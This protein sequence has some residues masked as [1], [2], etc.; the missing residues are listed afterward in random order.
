M[1]LN[2]DNLIHPISNDEI[3]PWHSKPLDVH[4]W[5]D[6]PEINSLVGDIWSE[7]SEQLENRSNNKGKSDPKRQLKVLLLDLY[8]AWL[9]DPSLC[10]GLSRNNN[11]YFVGTRYNALHIS[12]KIVD[13][14]DVLVAHGYL[15][16][17]KGSY[18]RQGSGKGNRTSRIRPSL[19]LQDKFAEL[20]IQLSDIDTHYY[21]EML[22][23]SDFET[24][25]EGNYTKSNGKKKRKYIEY[26][27]TDFTKQM[28]DDLAAYNELLSNT[29][30]D[31]VSL[32]E[33]FV[34]RINRDGKQQRIR[35]DQSKK[36]VRRIFSRDSW[37]MNGRFYGG[38]WQQIGSDYR[39][40]IYLNNTPAVEVD[41]KGLHAAILAARKGIVTTEDRYDLGKIICDRLDIKQQ[42]KVV[43]LLVL[44]AVNAKDRK[45]AYG[46]F[47]QAQPAGTVEKTLTND[48]LDNLL[49]AF[50]KRH[51]Y[52]E[53]GICSDKGIRLMNIDSQI[54]S[55]II[56]KFVELDKPI[57]SVHDSYIVCHDD[58]DFLRN[59]MTE[60]S[61]EV[62]GTD[63][64]VE[65]ER[66]SLQEIMYYRQYDFEHHLNLFNTFLVERS[67][68]V[69]S[70]YRERYKNFLIIKNN[71]PQIR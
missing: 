50:I 33:P 21:E 38:F 23:L 48:E 22:I 17:L 26:A 56:N 20:T 24:D 68:R 45:S 69:T 67:K 25:E 41:F 46:A 70:S 12:R 55:F 3:D 13:I 9:E 66:P 36:F 40:D 49:D 64:S 63:L 15:D 7:L 39:K 8:V 11:S 18:D 61:I 54:T 14:A 28:R 44:A 57:L 62:M 31:V 52:L 5:S 2:N 34:V 32:D 53:D 47:R 71:N 29:Y 19:K 35:I 42:R 58:A 59:C 27:D 60:A 4:T 65:Q 30:V 6:H 51:P 37:E 16:S 10:I 43:K 1:A